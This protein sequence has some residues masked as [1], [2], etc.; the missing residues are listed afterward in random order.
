MAMVDER[1]RLFGRLNV[2]DAAIGIVLLG[3]FPL[4][5]GSYLLFRTPLPTLTRVEPATLTYAPD[6]RITVRGENFRPYMRVSVGQYQGQNFLF[7]DPTQAQ[8]DLRAV[9]P[10]VYDVVLFDYAQERDRLPKALTIAPSALP[11]AQMVVVGMFG[12]LTPEQASGLKAGMAIPGVGEVTAV[13]RPVPLVTRVFARPG[14][15]E[16]PVPNARMVPVVLRMG[17]WVRSAQG[18]PECIGADVSIQP[19]SL[20][21]LQTALGTLPFQ[22]DEVR[23]TQPVEPLRVTVRLSGDPGVLA[24]VKKGDVDLGDVSNELSASGVVES[25][26]PGVS[27]GTREATLVLQAQRGSASWIYRMAPIRLGGAFTMLTPLYE[28]HGTV[29]RLSPAT[30]VPTLTP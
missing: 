5:Y 14:T 12:N 16:I 10:G 29:T 25:V 1:G 17:C 28:L 20:L 3:L 9:P 7:N 11:D 6:M 19:T 27:G 2:V 13:G 22:I 24:Q 23:G 18:Q 26:A 15:V 30:P 21:F 4:A 8:I